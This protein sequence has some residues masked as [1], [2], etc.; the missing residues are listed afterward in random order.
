MVIPKI[1]DEQT[2]QEISKHARKELEKQKKE[3]EQRSKHEFKV[4]KQK[5]RNTI[6]LSIC[7]IVVAGLIYY[8]SGKIQ[9]NNPVLFGNEHW[10][11]TVDILICGKERNDIKLLGDTNHHAGLSVL[12]TH[13]DGV[14]HLEPAGPVYNKEEIN[15]GEFFDAV[16]LKFSLTEILDKKNGDKCG[17]KEGKVKMFVNDKENS[18][19][20]NF[21]FKDGDRIKIVFE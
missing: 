21:N 20:R 12:H 1:S 2:E 7:L 13:G 10:H 15:L 8:F 18:E 4:K 14:I 6:I 17:D 9:R 3:Q 5:T 16:G 19:F 11:A